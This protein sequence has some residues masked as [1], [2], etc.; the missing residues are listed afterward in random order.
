MNEYDAWDAIDNF[1]PDKAL[2]IWRTLMSKENNQD[3]KDSL[4]SNSCYALL[5]LNRI[6][7]ARKI[8]LEL[9][10]KYQ[11]HKYLHQLCMVERKANN[12]NKALYYL[13]LEKEMISPDNTLA[14][15][16]NLYEFAKLN[17]LIGNIDKALKLS[18]DCLSLS[19][20]CDDDIMLACANRLL[21]DVYLKIDIEKAKPYYLKAKNIFANAEDIFAANE[22][23]QLMNDL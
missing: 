4:K 2:E 16:A 3:K 20:T 5:E 10:E 13:N 1:Q 19:L 22:I 11:T 17:E 14:L 12:Y 18:K 9:F 6:D 15:S 8:Y 21:G 7:E 23:D